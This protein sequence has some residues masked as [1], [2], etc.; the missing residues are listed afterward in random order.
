MIAYRNCILTRLLNSK[1]RRQVR[2]KANPKP[3]RPGG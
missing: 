2:R 3:F 1:H